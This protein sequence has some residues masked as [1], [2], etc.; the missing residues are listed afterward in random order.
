MRPSAKSLLFPI[1]IPAA[2]SL[3]LFADF[4]VGNVNIHGGTAGLLLLGLVCGVVV[5]L[6]EVIAVPLALWCLV[7]RPNLRTRNNLVALI[8]ACLYLVLAG[9]AYHYYLE[10][11][12]VGIAG[13]RQ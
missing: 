4:A 10:L 9:I 6:W 7:R 3:W 5:T 8:L 2:V 11:Q 13:N 12:R 1:A